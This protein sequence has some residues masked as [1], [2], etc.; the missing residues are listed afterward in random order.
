MNASVSRARSD[1]SVI[2]LSGC[3]SDDLAARWRVGHAIGVA[4]RER[5]FMLVVGGGAAP[6]P[7]GSMHSTAAEFFPPPDE[8]KLKYQIP[9]RQFDSA[10]TRPNQLQRRQPGEQAPPDLY[11]FSA[12][13]RFGE[14]AIADREVLGAQFDESAGYLCRQYR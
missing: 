4:F 14:P 6:D 12:M 1:V 3:R 2:G 8:E 13:N 5:G 7:I 9:H 10:G 11:E